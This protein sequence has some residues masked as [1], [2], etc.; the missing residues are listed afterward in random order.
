L[1]RDSTGE[2]KFMGNQKNNPFSSRYNPGWKNHLNFGWAQTGNQAQGGATEPRKPS[3][4][5]ELLNKFATMSQT[6]FENIQSTVA[7]QG[8]TIKSLKTQIGQLSKLVTT[9]VSKDVAGNT[10]DNPKEECKALTDKVTK[11]AKYILSVILIT[12]F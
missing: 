5:E 2:A 3:P 7:N 4:L 12:F 10:V 9:R 1:P 11:H 8:A 6:N